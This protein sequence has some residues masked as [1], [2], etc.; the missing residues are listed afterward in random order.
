MKFS[1]NAGLLQNVFLH[2]VFNQKFEL[3]YSSSFCLKKTLLQSVLLIRLQ[4]LRSEHWN[5][6]FKT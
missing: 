1:L 5:S 2:D 6:F 4:S 3:L